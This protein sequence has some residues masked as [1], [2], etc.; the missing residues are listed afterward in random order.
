MSSIVFF[1]Q[2]RALEF[3]AVCTSPFKPYM[4]TELKV[5]RV[6]TTQIFKVKKKRLKGQ[7]E[8]TFE[9]YLSKNI[10]KK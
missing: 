5:Q 6:K 1:F 4:Y 8:L 9:R 10:I 7:N 2:G 3:N